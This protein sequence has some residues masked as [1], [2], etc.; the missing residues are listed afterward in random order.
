MRLIESE[1]GCADFFLRNEEQISFSDL[2]AH[3]IFHSMRQASG[4]EE[5]EEEEI[6]VFRNCLLLRNHWS[7]HD[8]LDI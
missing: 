4:E 8:S 2:V 1:F 6:V 3:S 5:E 7:G